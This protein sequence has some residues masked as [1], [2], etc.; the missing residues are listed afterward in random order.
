MG[1]KQRKTLDSQ[2]LNETLSFREAVIEMW[3][4]VN[5]PFNKALEHLN[6]IEFDPYFICFYDWV[7]SESIEFTV[8]SGGLVD[9]VD[10]FIKRELV[11]KPLPNVLANKLKIHDGSHWEIIYLDDSEFGHDKVFQNVNEGN[12]IRNHKCKNSDQL[13]VFI[14]DGI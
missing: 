3:K 10:Y 8:L 7:L 4:S 1:Y 14:G 12:A 6:G 13:I 9:L 11:G 2:I 5:L